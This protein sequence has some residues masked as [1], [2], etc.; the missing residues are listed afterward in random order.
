MEEESFAL[1][2]FEEDEGEEEINQS[3]S[4]DSTNM[5]R[6]NDI[7]IELG[8]EL[9]DE[10][11]CPLTLECYRDPVRMVEDQ[12]I[13]EREAIEIVVS[14][15][16]VKFQKKVS[17]KLFISYYFVLH[18]R[19]VHSDIGAKKTAKNHSEV[20]FEKIFT[21]KNHILNFC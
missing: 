21:S 11:C 20:D 14:E 2:D 6:M 15:R 10:F 3:N 5:N 1:W 13:Y 8:I 17:R 19:T 18:L 16:Y 12:Q 7:E 4:I 9:P